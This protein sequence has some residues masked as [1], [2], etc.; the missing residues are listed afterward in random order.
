[1]NFIKEHKIAI[2]VISVCLIL[3]ILAGLSI[4]KMMFPSSAEDINGDRLVNAVAVEPEKINQILTELKGKSSVIDV[5]YNK[6]IRILKFL[7][8]FKPDTKLE[9]AKKLTSIITSNLTNDILNYYDIEVFLE[10]DNSEF[11]AIG[12]CFKGEKTFYFN[13]DG[14]LE[15]EK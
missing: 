6:N 15:D 11:P 1:M 13:G 14:E 12:Q 2:I 10:A 8:S 3:I 4:S 5:T 9:D 7:I